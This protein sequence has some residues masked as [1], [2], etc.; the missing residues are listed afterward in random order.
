[1]T[2]A[3][4]WFDEPLD[5]L[6]RCVRA[7]P[8]IADRLVAVDG[9]YSR[10]P[11]A[12][13]RSPVEQADTIRVAA[14]VAGLD[15]EIVEPK[16]VWSGQCEKREHLMNLAAEGSDWIVVVDTDHIL[17]GARETVRHEIDR[18]P[19]QIA[20]VKVKFHTPVNRDRPLGESAAHEWHAGLADTTTL[21]PLVFRAWQQWTVGPHHWWYSAVDKEGVRRWVW[22]GDGTSYP[23]AGSHT[24]VAPYF[25]EHRCLFRQP[26]QILANREF[27][28]DRDLIVERTGREDPVAA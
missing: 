25:V 18:L 10:W 19:P 3:L 2:A 27:C 24:L 8:A 1:M 23:D 28:R 5:E 21:I 6:E 15:V 13:A 12:K 17:H 26:K 7:L 11:G 16:R 9:G 4:A 22:S 20:A 14:R